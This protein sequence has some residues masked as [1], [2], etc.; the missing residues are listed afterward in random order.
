MA[1]AVQPFSTQQ[2]DVCIVPTDSM[3]ARAT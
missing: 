3:V 2:E 1:E